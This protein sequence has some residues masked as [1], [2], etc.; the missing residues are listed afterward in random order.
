ML[1]GCVMRAPFASPGKK[2][3]A[4]TQSDNNN[5]DGDDSLMKMLSDGDHHV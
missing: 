3:N 4:N 1:C 2:E 5:G